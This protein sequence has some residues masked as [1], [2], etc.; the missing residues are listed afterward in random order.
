MIRQIMYEARD[1]SSVCGAGL[2]NPKMKTEAFGQFDREVKITHV[3]TSG[4]RMRAAQIGT[5]PD[6]VWVP[7]GDSP[8]EAWR[9]QM[10]LF[11]GEYRSTSY[12]PRGVGETTSDAAAGR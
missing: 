1:Y 8:A 6:I 4:A 12:D 9:Q 5:G 10:M 2:A 3:Q 7:G 11:A